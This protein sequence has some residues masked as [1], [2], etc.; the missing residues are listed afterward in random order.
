MT[1]CV[2]APPPI[3]NDPPRPADPRLAT[4]LTNGP[5]RD[6]RPLDAGTPDR[7]IPAR[8]WRDGVIAGWRRASDRL[9]TLDP[10]GRPRYD[11][12]VA[13]VLARLQRYTSVDLLVTCYFQSGD[14]AAE[15]VRALFPNVPHV[16][17]LRLI[18]GA[19]WG[20]RLREIERSATEQRP[21]TEQHIERQSESR[22][23]EGTPR[24]PEAF[25]QAAVGSQRLAAEDWDGARRA[26]QAAVAESPTVAEYWHDL[27]VARG[28]LGD[29]RWAQDALDRANR[30][31]P[32]RETEGLLVEVR[33]IRRLVRQLRD[34]PHD[35]ALNLRVGTL[36][37]AWEHGDLALAHLTRAVD[38]APR[39]PL[40]RVHLGLEY[41]FREEWNAAEACYRAAQELGAD[42]GE[43]QRLIESCRAHEPPVEQSGV[44]EAPA[45]CSVPP[46]G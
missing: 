21:L 35:A 30:L 34:R 23:A 24:S 28:R 33:A 12:L 19:A 26:F 5:R 18:E 36:L 4:V 44:E 16:W 37:M 27:G 3:Q 41:H 15:A 40:P 17:D 39:W 31:Q 42:E 11:A 32:A 38:L 43:L 10:R 45:G 8:T 20:Q 9:A 46:R 22:S 6:P 29:W 14:F 25:E 13:V 2:L 1:S 7:A